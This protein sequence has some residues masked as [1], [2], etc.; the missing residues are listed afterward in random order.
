MYDFFQICYTTKKINNAIFCFGFW[1]LGCT[2]KTKK[3]KKW[4]YRWSEPFGTKRF[5]TFIFLVIFW[6]LLIRVAATFFFKT[7]FCT[8]KRAIFFKKMALQMV[9][10]LFKNYPIF[11]YIIYDFLKKVSRGSR[12]TCLAKILCAVAV[13]LGRERLQVVRQTAYLG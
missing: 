1:A 12:P 10:G 6:F 2:K 9:F 4:S 13:H 11:R 5:K 8:K 7:F 3:I